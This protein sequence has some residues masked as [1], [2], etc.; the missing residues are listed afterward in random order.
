MPHRHATLHGP[1]EKIDSIDE[2]ILDLLKE[3]NEI[4]QQVIEKKVENKLPI[5]V[6]EREKAKVKSFRQKAEDRGL[7]AEWAEDFL[8]MI[9]TASRAHQSNDQ[10]PR[11]T[12]HTRANDVVFEGRGSEQPDAD[13]GGQH[14]GGGYTQGGGGLDINPPAVK[15]AQALGIY[16]RAGSVRVYQCRAGAQQHITTLVSLCK[17]RCSQQT[18]SQKTELK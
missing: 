11:S 7:D 10:F 17:G 15:H 12:K 16:I 1:R 8:R 4:V 2:Q 18:G 13:M 6:S 9:M 14:I 5:F 3:R